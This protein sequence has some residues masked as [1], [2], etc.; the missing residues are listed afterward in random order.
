[1]KAMVLHTVGKPLELTNIPIPSPDKKQLLLK[2]LTCCVCRT[3]LHIVD[4]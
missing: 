4:G 1:M 2:V 3:D